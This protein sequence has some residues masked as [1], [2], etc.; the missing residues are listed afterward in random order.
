MHCLQFYDTFRHILTCRHFPEFLPSEV[1]VLSDSA[2]F[3]DGDAPAPEEVSVIW[4]SANPNGIHLDVICWGLSAEN[5]IR[6]GT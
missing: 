5:S 6:M 2:Q 1:F 4:G 3:L